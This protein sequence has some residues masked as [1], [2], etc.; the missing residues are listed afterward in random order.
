ML[1][2]FLV[3]GGIIWIRRF[4]REM[5]D[6]GNSLKGKRAGVFVWI[7]G[8]NDLLL[9]WLTRGRMIGWYLLFCVVGAC[10]LTACITDL[11]TCQVHTFIWWIAGAAATAMLAAAGSRKENLIF[12]VLFCLLQQL[13]FSRFYGRADCH[14]FCVCAAAEC[15]MGISPAGFFLHMLFAF[16]ALALVQTFRRNIGADGNLKEAVPFLPYITVSFW[17]LLFLAVRHEDFSFLAY[18]CKYY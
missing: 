4:D 14:G 13:L 5:T 6:L 10:L 16:G 3:L 11:Q 2:F 15:A 8:V 7:C 1:I 17:F 9:I 18:L 12:L